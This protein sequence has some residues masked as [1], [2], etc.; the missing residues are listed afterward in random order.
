MKSFTKIHSY[1][2]ACE[3]GPEVLVPGRWMDSKKPVRIPYNEY[4]LRQFDEV[5][6]L[7]HNQATSLATDG[8][9][10]VY[11]LFMRLF[12]AYDHNGDDKIGQVVGHGDI[13]LNEDGIRETGTFVKTISL[14][15]Y[16][17]N[18]GVDIIHLLPIT[19]VGRAGM[20]GN[21]GS[22]YAIKNPFELEPT[23][24]DPFVPM[25]ISEQFCAFVEAAH[26]LGMKVVLEF[27]LR[28]GS[29]DSDWITQYPEWFYWIKVKE[30]GN[31]GPPD[32]D[33]DQLARIKK[34][35]K[36]KGEYIEPSVAY[37]QKFVAPPNPEEIEFKEGIY[38]AH[39][40]GEAVTVAT[41]FADWPPDDP[42]PT[43]KDVTYL[44]LYHLQDQK[45]NYIAYNTVRF[46]DPELK[47]DENIVE[48]IWGKICGIIPFYQEHFNIDGVMVDMGH[49]L[50][51]ELK[52]KVVEKAR[53]LNKNFI[54]WDES[55]VAKDEHNSLHYNGIIGDLWYKVQKKN[56]LKSIM[57]RIANGANDTVPMFGT[58]E[59]HNSPRFSPNNSRRREQAL[60][61]FHLLPNCIPFIHNGVENNDE[62]P[63]NTGLNFNKKLMASLHGKPMALFDISCLNWDGKTTVPDFLVKLKNIRKGYPGLFSNNPF[64]QMDIEDSSLIGFEKIVE[65]A[66]FTIV[67]NMS[68]KEA[69]NFEMPGHPG[70]L[71]LGHGEKGLN[72][73]ARVPASGF[74]LY[75]KK[76]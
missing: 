12:S 5:K 19:K 30:L 25:D 33:Q 16:L 39:S 9:Q 45:Y 11:N 57:D 53:A 49:A 73:V 1:L 52:R 67:F 38:S 37:Q 21:L 62:L 8:K 40:N 20:K 48:G 60:M 10:V 18:L 26:A 64:A 7:S 50:P 28:T 69:K 46:Y 3:K 70:D 68:T 74:Q 71:I 13:T 29:L 41:A 24:A 63:V 2:A 36:G 4:L 54:F 17:K 55:F 43:W 42:Q 15:P 22:P 76:A 47:K 6:K 14:L 35:E 72:Q 59:T 31:Y 44:R 58:P 75:Y 61:L 65:G 32:F 66:K 56:G 51:I 34:L 23:L 27:I